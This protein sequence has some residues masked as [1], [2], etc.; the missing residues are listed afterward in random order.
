[1]L[2]IK[3]LAAT[4]LMILGFIAAPAGSADLRPGNIVT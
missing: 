3:E 2:R 1:M 4:L